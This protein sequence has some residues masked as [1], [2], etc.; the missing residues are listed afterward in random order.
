[1]KLGQNIRDFKAFSRKEGLYYTYYQTFSA[2]PGR[3]GYFI[4]TILGLNGIFSKTDKQNPHKGP[5]GALLGIPFG[6]LGAILGGIVNFVLVIPGYIGRGIDK[7][8]NKFM[9]GYDAFMEVGAMDMKYYYWFS[10]FFLVP[11]GFMALFFHK[12]FKKL[13]HKPPRTM[14]APYGF[15]FGAIPE[16]IRWLLISPIAYPVCI[17]NWTVDNVC[18]GIQSFYSWVAQGLNKTWAWLTSNKENVTSP[19]T[20]DQQQK[21][22]NQGMD[23]AMAKSQNKKRS[24]L[25]RT[26][27][28]A[29][30]VRQKDQEKAKTVQQEREKNAAKET[31]E[32]LCQQGEDLFAI[33]GLSKSG[34]IDKK[35]IKRAYHQQLLE[36]A[37]DK[38][39]AFIRKYQ[40]KNPSTQFTDEEIGAI[41]QQRLDLVTSAY[42]ILYIHGWLDYFKTYSV[43]QNGGSDFEK[44]A[45]GTQSTN[46]LTKSNSPFFSQPAKTRRKLTKK[47]PVSAT[48]KNN[49]KG[50]AF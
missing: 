20:S 16:I 8:I 34:G 18:E 40:E 2:L 32:K 47:A 38:N 13:F 46:N 23:A 39:S 33:L 26:P 21:T 48:V 27:Q 50:S 4:D 35:S 12:M 43:S 6:C 30:N 9:P 29:E 19:K 45:V 31:G 42:N 7:L 15:I 28:N 11:L 24:T 41:R 1:M 10:D 5:F 25:K 37:Q 3:I 36:V 14:A 44:F 22:V 17:F 49:V